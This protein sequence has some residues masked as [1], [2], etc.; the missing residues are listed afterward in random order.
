MPSVR[1]TVAATSTATA[2]LAGPGA[3][4]APVEPDGEAAC[5]Q[6]P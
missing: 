2:A 5:P 1:T 6:A 3:A 4:A